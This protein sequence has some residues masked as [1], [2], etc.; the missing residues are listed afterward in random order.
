MDPQ[1]DDF[2]EEFSDGLILGKLINL[3]AADTVDIR[4]VSSVSS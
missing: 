1:S 3:V 4:F 2:F